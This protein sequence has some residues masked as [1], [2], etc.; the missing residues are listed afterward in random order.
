MDDRLTAVIANVRQQSSLMTTYYEQPQRCAV[1]GTVVQCRVLGSTNSFGSPDLDLRPAE[2]QRSTM[3]VWLQECPKCCFVNSNLENTTPNANAVLES[4]KYQ[5]I[6]ADTKHPDLARRFARYAELNAYDHED[7]G[8]ALIRSAW[9]CDD[10]GATAL[11][12][13]YRSQTAD[14]LLSLQP[15]EDNEERVTLATALVDVLRRALRFPEAKALATT[16]RS[17]KSVAS[18]EIIASVLDYQTRLCDAK[19]TGCYS[20]SDANESG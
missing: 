7:A 14:L 2:M 9:V 20:V 8:V 12:I 16:V 13:A 10:E 17:Y 5:Q 11:A 1:C 3:N 4:S 18:N 19:D 6:A 15:F